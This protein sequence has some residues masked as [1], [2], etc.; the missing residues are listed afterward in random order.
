M[1][2]Y[3]V[4]VSA[5]CTQEVCALLKYWGSEYIYSTEPQVTDRKTMCMTV[6]SLARVASRGFGEP[7]FSLCLLAFLFFLLT[8]AWY[9]HYTV[10]I[11]FFF[12]STLNFDHATCCLF[13][14]PR[15]S[16]IAFLALVK[17]WRSQEVGRLHFSSASAMGSSGSEDRSSSPFLFQNFEG[18]CASS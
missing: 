15:C 9:S 5:I 11:S 13:M 12:L 4:F 6:T 18:F 1:L 10:I 16:K 3:I 17:W 8:K 14:S 7:V 2:L